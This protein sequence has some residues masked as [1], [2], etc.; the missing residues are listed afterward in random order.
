MELRSDIATAASAIT[1]AYDVNREIRQLGRYLRAGETVQRLA[2]GI[3]GA[4][5][6]LLAVTNHRVLFLRDGRSGQV[7]EG[8]PLGRLSSAGWSPD[9][10]RAT[11]SVSDSNSTAVLR[12]VES[13]LARGVV[14]LI[15]RLADGSSGHRSDAGQHSA[16]EAAEALH[17][18]VLDGQG[19]YGGTA[20]APAFSGSSGGPVSLNSSTHGGGSY[21]APDH[22]A[23]GSTGRYGSVGGGSMERG[24]GSGFLPSGRTLNGAGTIGATSLFDGNHGVREHGVREHSVREHSVRVFESTVS[25]STVSESTPASCQTRPRPPR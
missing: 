16:V 25:E 8:F 17:R 14:E 23:H 6:G 2:T 9:G 21:E 7:S 1:S 20:G 11:I 4:G 10:A 12:Q 18:S 3:Y 15:R 22:G 13:D 5:A 19:G 24:L